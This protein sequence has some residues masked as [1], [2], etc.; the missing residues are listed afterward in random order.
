MTNTKA[1]KEALELLE[2]AWGHVDNTNAN[3]RI[4]F[5]THDCCYHCNTVGDIIKAVRENNA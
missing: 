3:C 5:T 4:D 2:T 1:I